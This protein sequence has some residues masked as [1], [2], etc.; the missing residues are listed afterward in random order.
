MVFLLEVYLN[1][2][3]SMLLQRF[4]LPRPVIHKIQAKKHTKTPAFYSL[5]L[6]HCSCQRIMV[7]MEGSSLFRFQRSV[8]Q[9]SSRGMGYFPG[10]AGIVK[11]F[12]QLNQRSMTRNYSNSGEPVDEEAI[13]APKTLYVARKLYTTPKG[14]DF[15]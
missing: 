11:S 14:L 4:I 8:L 7:S 13:H 3:F 6:L 10:E 5:S 9:S 2:S 15:G 1:T 12:C